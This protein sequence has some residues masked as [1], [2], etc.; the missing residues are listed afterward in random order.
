MTLTVRPTSQ[1]SLAVAWATAQNNAAILN[2]ATAIAALPHPHLYVE[3]LRD[4][5]ERGYFL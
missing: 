3:Q 1:P 5:T 2:G 4:E